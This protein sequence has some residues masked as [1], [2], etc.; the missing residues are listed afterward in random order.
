M[1]FYGG[2]PSSNQ[3]MS[4]W[5]ISELNGGFNRK[6]TVFYGPFSSKP[7]LMTPEGTCNAIVSDGFS[8]QREAKSKGMWLGLRVHYA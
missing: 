1:G 6:I 4:G 8:L 5:K 3:N 7:C 2:L